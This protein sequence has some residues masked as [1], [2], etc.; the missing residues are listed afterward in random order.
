[1]SLT[2]LCHA[3]Q[4]ALL[5]VVFTT[6]W[7]CMAS[8]E[9]VREVVPGKEVVVSFGRSGQ[10]RAA[11]REIARISVPGHME[12]TET[13]GSPAIGVA[14][15]RS[16]VRPQSRQPAVVN[17]AEIAAMCS[18]LRSANPGTSIVCEPNILFHSSRTP[19]DPRYS[20]LYAMPKINAPTAWDDTIGASSVV[21]AVLDSGMDLSHPDLSP[22]ISVNSGE[23]AG[24]GIDDDGNGFI[25]DRRGYDFV[26]NDANPTDDH[27]HGTHCAG[28]IGARG[29][30]SEGVV[31]INWQVGLL[32]VKVLDNNGDGFL[33]DVAAGIEYAADRGAAV[34]NLSLGSESYSQTL[35]NAVSYAAT[36]GV[37][38][39]AAAG[40][41]GTN[42]DVVPIYPASLTSNAIMAVAAT[43]SSDGLASFSNFGAISVDVGAPGVGI[44]STVPIN[45][46]GTLSGTSM[47]APLVAGLAALVKSANTS[48]TAA[49]IKDIIMNSVD[50]VSS[51]RGKTVTGGRINAA[52]AVAMALGQ[53][54][55]VPSGSK[56]ALSLSKQ[57]GRLKTY[58]FGSI[59]D[60]SGTPVEGETIVLMCGGQRV[61][62]KVSDS[63]GNYE[64][65]RRNP[66][67]R[68]KCYVKDRSGTRSRTRTI[69]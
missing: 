22:N 69:G 41:D 56:N 17:D 19:N 61:A 13:R 29:N 20:S 45:S 51:L 27:L 25:D 48:L 68:I 55:P 35:Q 7:C 2:S 42:N 57:R 18:A 37:L 54:T 46:Y 60:S 58:L 67:Q 10:L 32:P 21:V 16:R 65:R 31:G 38:I 11:A 3:L 26:N 39:V 23:I 24:N 36:Q 47:A 14:S 4:Q 30:N 6:G 43:N 66:V 9:S 12:L 15:V 62:S 34:I 1:M 44:V 52:N 8:A 50:Q 53:P 28:T 40:N 33:S 64:F 5:A 63:E 59:V 49:Q